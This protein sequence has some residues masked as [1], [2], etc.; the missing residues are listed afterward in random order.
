MTKNIQSKSV[1]IDRREIGTR[2][3]GIL[4]WEWVQY[5]EKKDGNGSNNYNEKKGEAKG[6]IQ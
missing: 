4:R 3:G 6:R 2:E 1:E 5:N